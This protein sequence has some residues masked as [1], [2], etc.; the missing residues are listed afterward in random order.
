MI[1]QMLEVRLRTS[2]LF[3]SVPQ[4]H[5][6][7]QCF[8]WERWMNGERSLLTLRS[9]SMHLSI[10]CRCRIRHIWNY[11]GQPFKTLRYQ[12]LHFVHFICEMCL[13][14]CNDIDKF[15]VSLLASHILD[16]LTKTM[17]CQNGT[18]VKIWHRYI[19]SVSRFVRSRNYSDIQTL[20]L[21]NLLGTH[22]TN[23][24]AEYFA[25]ESHL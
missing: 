19:S 11:C 1:A 14:R 22:S 10:N 12:S 18:N 4:I 6:F 15:A 21:M 5:T 24:S 17:V 8:R 7:G 2:I 23:A 25:H 13:T 3:E 20:K 16:E 9:S